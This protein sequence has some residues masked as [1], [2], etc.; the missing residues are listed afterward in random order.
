MFDPLRPPNKLRMLCLIAAAVVS[1]P[2]R[3]DPKNSHA[4]TD[5]IQSSEPAIDATD[6]KLVE[7]ESIEVL[8]VAPQS[9]Q[10]STL[11]GDSL[12]LQQSDTLGK[13]LENQ[14]GVSNASFGPGVG[15][16]V[17]RGLSGSR[18]RIL[19][20]GISSH[21]AST[22]SPDHAVAI[23]PL[24]AE[25]ID[26]VRGP[27]TIRYGG[28]AIGGT[29]N[30][31]DNRIP[32]RVPEKPVEGAIES[33]FDNNADGTNSAFKLDLGEKSLALRL[34]G[35]YRH[36]NDTEIPG[37]AID[38]GAIREQFG[39]SNIINAQGSIPNTNS[40][41]YGGSAGTAWL[42]ESAMAGMS[43]SHYENRYGIPKGSHGIDPS[44]LDGL[45]V[46]LPEIDIGGF[47]DIL[48]PEAL[49]PSIRIEMMQTRYDFKSE[50]FPS[51]PG[52]ERLAFRYGL[53]DYE[54]TEFEGGLPFTV[55]NN[56]AAEGRFEI[57]HK[58]FDIF[59]GTFGAQWLDRDFSALGVETFVPP[60][61]S[62]MLGLFTLQKLTIDAW[63]L[64]AGLRTESVR[65]DPLADSLK[66]PGPPNQPPQF[67]PVALPSDLSFRAD[68]ASVSARWDVIDHASLTLSLSRAKRAPDIQELLALGPH[69]STRTFEVGNV[70]LT[71][72]TV[73]M[74]D[75]GFDWHSDRLAA[76]ANG[77]Y[78][79][80]ENYIYQKIEPDGFYNFHEA[81]F[82]SDCVSLADCL[83]VYAYDQR[84]AL[85]IGYEAEA[86]ATLADT[87]FGQLKLTVFSDWV[88]G[89]FADGNR[90]DVP[91]LP[92]LR[93]GAEIGFGDTHWNTSLRYTRAEA[94]NRPGNNETAT[95][96]YHLLNASADYHW[97]GFEPV[98]FWVFAKASN[99]LNQ[100]MRSS[101]SFL[102]NFAPE[103]GRSIVVGFRVTY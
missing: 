59:T 45:E 43:V 96:G 70:Q 102:R 91:R 83:P 30:V 16:P 73:N 74:A 87:R 90:D 46:I 64:E 75:F 10:A 28:G 5:T 99:L 55:F 37:N 41:S 23:E 101:V 49:N 9:P 68:S 15:V 57:D 89:Q 38:A 78:N 80:T 62:D 52:I 61:Q 18:V 8:G 85:F 81:Q 53:V 71:N 42:G 17:I 77:Y 31:K 6:D 44:H 11:S 2:I 93:L 48:G 92:P 1:T 65:I 72:E 54:H 3:A 14:L 76:R 21:D 60:T 27:D 47:E 50:W 29:V 69:L 67:S 34:G 12:R 51:I 22:I 79:W 103:P 82:Y 39:L 4:P 20:D 25:Q 58:L 36:R 88:R 94:Q 35:F 66:F 32:E 33:R 40:E 84:N 97:K 95:A 24:F 98:D 13:T 7:L 63:T 86:Q 19:Q 56:Q 100:E 26:I